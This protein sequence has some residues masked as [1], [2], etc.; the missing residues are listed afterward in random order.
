MDHTAELARAREMHGL[1][2]LLSL[3]PMASADGEVTS[4]LPTSTPTES[5]D[6]SCYWN[7]YYCGPTGAADKRC[8]ASNRDMSHPYCYDDGNGE[9]DLYSGTVDDEA[10]SCCNER[11]SWPTTEAAVSLSKTCEPI[12]RWCLTATAFAN[13]L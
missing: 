6:C 9:D 11:G 12:L 10:G 4:S 5:C 13:L 2:A 8:E 1:L 3:I 7:G